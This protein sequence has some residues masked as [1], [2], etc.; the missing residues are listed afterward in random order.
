MTAFRDVAPCSLVGITDVS[1]VLTASIIRDYTIWC[2]PDDGDS[3]QLW[4]AGQFLPDYKTQQLRRQFSLH[5]PPWEPEISPSPMTC[6]QM[7]LIKPIY[8]LPV[9]I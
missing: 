4:E 9:R 3:K 6:L 7:Q 5:S 2:Q 1:V 8:W